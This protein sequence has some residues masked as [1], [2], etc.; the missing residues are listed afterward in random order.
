MIPVVKVSDKGQLILNALADQDVRT[1]DAAIGSK[2]ISELTGLAP[3]SVP[4]VLNSLVKKDLVDKTEDSPRKYFL[5]VDLGTI[6][7]E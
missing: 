4:G 2:D 7:F 5:K 6:S 1:V 3:T